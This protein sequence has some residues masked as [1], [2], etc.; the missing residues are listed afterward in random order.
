MVPSSIC[1]GAAA[2]ALATLGSDSTSIPPVD[3]RAEVVRGHAEWCRNVYA[4]SRRGALT[5]A[6]AARALV[7]R[8]SRETLDAAR[9]AWTGARKAYGLTEALRF[10][11]GPIEAV[12]TS[13]N[14]WPVDEAYIDA[15][16]GRADSGIINDPVHFPQIGRTVLLVSNERGGETNISIGW[17]AIEF[18]LWGQDLFADGPGRRPF[19][20][21]AQDKGH[22][23]T[24]RGEYL[25]AA[26]DLL[27]QQ[28]GELEAAWG[29]G[30]GAYRHA[31]E[32]DPDAALRKM[33]TGAI[34]LTAFEL[35]GERL[36]VAYE[37]K[38]QEQEH[39]CFSDTTHTDL[40]A[41]QDGI[42]AIFTG[43]HG[44]LGFGPGLLAYLRTKDA[45]IADDL[46][47]KIARTRK[48]LMAI[49]APFD[50]AV[51]GDDDAPGRKAIRAALEALQAQTDAI[52]IAG[53]A[54]GFHLP[55]E[56]GG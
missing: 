33:L 46:A 23:A 8:P 55:L 35:H 42:I 52:A 54:L 4:E 13:L 37:T 22:N 5:V 3:L 53:R 30:P 11:D 44:Q 6:V 41:N 45:A 17:H 2:F 7:A 50:Q 19:T 47:A 29:T 28:L 31:F 12:E 49:P 15:V 32:K 40:V 14:A 27:A 10:C 43:A 51:L 48:A 38:D 34:V 24:R 21:Y 25:I 20:D 56:P 39:S 18:L 9:A 1:L 26:A 16:A 36:A